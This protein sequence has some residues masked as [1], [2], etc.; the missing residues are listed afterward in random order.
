VLPRLSLIEIDTSI[1]KITSSFV[2]PD[3]IARFIINSRHS[4]CDRLKNLA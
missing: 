1:F 3:H 2:G 4:L